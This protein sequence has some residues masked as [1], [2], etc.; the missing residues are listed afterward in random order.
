MKPTRLLV[1][2]LFITL[3]L[4]SKTIAQ[5]LYE[6][7]FKDNQ[8]I[9]YVGLLVYFNEEKVYMRV[10]YNNKNKY[11]VVN[12]DYQLKNGT[13]TRGRKYYALIGTNTRYFTSPAEPS[14]YSPDHLIW[15]KNGGNE[16]LITPNLNNMQNAKR[17]T[18]FKALAANTMTDTY[19]RR[20]YGNA[21]NDYI[22]L[23]KR[24]KLDKNVP[25]PVSTTNTG[26]ASKMHLLVIANTA[27]G[28]IGQSCV[29]DQR[30]LL[31]EFKGI[32]ETLNMGFQPYLINGESFSKENLQATLQTMK[33]A[34]NDVVVV[35]YRGHGYRF[36]NQT[37]PYPQLDLRYSNY[38]R[39]SE[40]T[41]INLEEVYYAVT[42]KGA[43]LNIVLAD[44]C[45]NEIGL[46]Q[47]TSSDF[48]AMQSN[49]NYSDTRLGRLF[50]KSSGNLIAAASTAGEVSWAN[51]SNGGFFTVSF[52]QA[53]REEIGYLGKG[54]ANWNNLLNTTVQSARYKSSN[55]ACANCTQ[56]NGIF[57]STITYR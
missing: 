12:T 51:N 22:A 53:L 41:S 46:N 20:F 32:A 16:P 35:I 4:P 21:E 25:P 42:N 24:F 28:D 47:M 38:K 3:C 29:I 27:I 54:D 6:I 18:L 52:L 55:T 26:G 19:L 9:S 31:A 34:K 17:A 57:Y 49:R 45:N 8:N 37:K 50:L 40:N 48:M 1:Y 56:Q 10:S 43:R 2:L 33:P 15:I 30:N 11:H 5:E 39:V 23:K 36:K 7:Q 44:C 13:D 14:G